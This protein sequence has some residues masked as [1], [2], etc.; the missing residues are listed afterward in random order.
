MRRLHLCYNAP[1][2]LSHSSPA[3]PAQALA[4]P[5]FDG[6]LLKFNDIFSAKPTSLTL[7]QFCNA[8]GIFVQR[9]QPK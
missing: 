3:T 2:G 4:G 8:A 5:G 1:A 7:V 6:N 9:T